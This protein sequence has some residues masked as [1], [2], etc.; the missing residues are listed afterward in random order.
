MNRFTI[1]G[2]GI[3]VPRYSIGID[4]A[5]AYAKKGF[6][7]TEEQGRQLTLLYRMTGVQRR[8][9]VVLDGPEEMSDRHSFFPPPNGAMQQGPSIRARMEKYENESLP[10]AV[11]AS[12]AALEEARMKPGQITHL[13]TVSCSGFAAPG[14]DI[15]LIKQLGLPLTCQRTHVG[16]MGCHGA[17]NALRVA[18]GF[19]ESDPNARVLLCAVELCS[20]HYHYGWNPDQL[21]A[22]AL[23][24]DG[25]AAI[26]GGASEEN[27]DDWQIHGTGSCLVPDSEDAMTWRIGNNGFIMSL[28]SRVPELIGSHLRPWMESWLEQHGLTIDAVKSWAVHPG[29]P[30][31]L[32]SVVK[33]LGLPKDAVDVSKEV[34]KNHGNMSSP[35]IL[36]ILNRL[37][38]ACAPRPCVALGFGPG[39]MAEATLFA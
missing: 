13:V 5:V 24:A 10:L 28:S 19:V 17:L 11:T 15:G 36:F 18:R 4:E 35:T 16:F 32:G 37:R 30:R 39:L 38:E 20:L 29:G 8:H 22:N 23:F 6:C 21:V 31:I 3:A 26:V 7:E 12:R 9:T 25:S 1:F 2:Q 27:S 34:L 33:A 14:V